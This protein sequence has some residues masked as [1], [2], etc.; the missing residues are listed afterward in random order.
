MTRISLYVTAPPFMHVRRLGEGRPPLG[1]IL[2]A[3]LA[4]R[5]A[6][7]EELRSLF[8]LAPWCPVC[9]LLHSS[10]E[11]RRVPRSPRMC[12]V[13]SL[14][15]GGGASSILAAVILLAGFVYPMQLN[16]WSS[17]LYWLGNIAFFF[18]LAYFFYR[19]SIDRVSAWGS[20]V[21]GAFDLYR[22]DLLKKLGYKH[23]P[24]TR[25]KERELWSRISRQ[26]IYGDLDRV[27][28]HYVEEP[29]PTYPSLSGTSTKAKLEMTKGVRA[30]SDEYLI[31]CLR[32]RNT[33]KDEE[34]NVVVTDKLP[35]DLYYQWES[36]RV[37]S[38]PPESVSGVNPYNFKIGSIAGN[39][40]VVLTYKG[41]RRNATS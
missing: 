11:R 37:D 12:S 25:Q 29:G 4:E 38:S 19:L 5:P 39:N 33:A 27:P 35:D 2:L 15:G 24:A 18:A 20:M 22:S 26:I 3:D 8:A 10:A 1:S 6:T 17:R 32:I 34:T 41:I 28:P 36:A 21:K 23:E 16:S 13:S 7:A 30:S 40:E 14:E 9:V 31:F